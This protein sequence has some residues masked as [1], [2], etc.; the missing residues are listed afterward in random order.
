M[1]RRTFTVQY[2]YKLNVYQTVD[3]DVGWEGD[4]AT[5]SKDA[6]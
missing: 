3:I 4:G 5:V 6:K 2:I 1:S